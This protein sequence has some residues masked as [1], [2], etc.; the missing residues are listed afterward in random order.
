MLVRSFHLSISHGHQNAQQLPSREECPSPCL[1]PLT[2]PSLHFSIA[3]HADPCS[4]ALSP[5]LCTELTLTKNHTDNNHCSL[6]HLSLISAVSL[7][8]QWFSTTQT[9]GTGSTRMSLPGL[10]TT[11]K[12]TSSGS[13]RKKMAHPLKSQSFSRKKVTARLLSARARS[14]PSST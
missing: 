7:R 4:V 11:S 2:L 13:R 1:S 10:R 14:L 5:D 9:T 6:P 3:I 8:L 12:K